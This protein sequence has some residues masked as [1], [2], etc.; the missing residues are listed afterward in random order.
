MRFPVLTV[1]TALALAA[2][3]T[4]ALAQD[5]GGGLNAHA[6][7]ITPQD[8]DIRDHY[9]TQRPGSLTPMGWFVGGVAEYAH[10]P[11]VLVTESDGSTEVRPALDNVVA[12]NLGAGFSPIDR[13]RISASAPLFLTSTSFG[14]GQ[15]FGI[16]DT[17]IDLMG[18]L[19]DPADTNGIGIA[20]V[21]WVDLPTGDT[22]KFLGRR[23]LAGGGV[24]AASVEEPT[25]TLT[26]NF[27]LQGEP[28]LEG[29]RNLQGGLGLVAAVGGNYLIDDHSSI[30]LEARLTAPLSENDRAGTGSPSEATLSYRRRTDAGA[31]FTGGLAAPLT[32]GAGAAAFRVFLGG[33]FGKVSAAAP[34][35]S[36]MDGITD[37]VDACPREPETFNDY[38]DEDGCPDGV[39]DLVVNVTWRGEPYAGAELVVN[40]PDGE[41]RH[42]LEEP[43][44]RQTAAPDTMWNLA[45]TKGDCLAGD[46]KKLVRS[47][48]GEVELPLQLVPSATMIV[49][50]TDKAQNPV[51]GVKLLW[52]T[53]RPECVPES[54]EMEPKGPTLVDIG[55]GRHKLIVGAPGYRVVEVPILASPGDELPVEV[56]LTPTKLKVTGTKIEILEKVNFET[57]RATIRS[58]SFDLLNEV[59]EVIL[60]NPKGTIEVQGHTDDR[61]AD[62]DNLSLSQNRAEAV[63]DYLIQRGVDRNRLVAMGFGESKPI[64]DNGTPDGRAQNRRVEFVILQ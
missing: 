14:E 13:L 37:D 21:P 50:V 24:V 8:G 15:G 18:L 48:D 11:L 34:K 3:S 26:T 41:T 43:V 19:V 35:D 51:P 12:L 28:R 40:G 20:V 57:G 6:L 59:A 52:D 39:S 36:D 55:A 30:G 4:Q 54:I 16:G 17:R 45:A 25:F 33:G 1:V 49:R 42:Q 61:G 60:R 2:G 29:L 46:A 63:R 32:P 47:G 27:G 5:D 9:V 58:D 53:T 23:T 31:F 56:S 7:A 22:T 64:A 62:A 10:R 38:V 44:F